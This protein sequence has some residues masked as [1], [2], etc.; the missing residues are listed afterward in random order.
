MNAPE[1]ESREDLQ[2]RS[3][4]QPAR[5]LDLQRAFYTRDPDYVPP[6][7]MA[8]SWQLDPRK[9]P[10]FR[11]ADVGLFAAF[12][13]RTCVG[14]VSTCRDRLHDEFHGDRI[15][16][17]GHFEAADANVARALVEHSGTW[18]RARGADALRGPVDLSTNNRCGLRIDD[19][20]GP[21]V[22][23]MPHN[24]PSYAG[25][26]EAAGLQKAK[27]LLAL[28][29]TSNELDH[30]RIDR[31]AA[32]LQKKAQVTL[33]N[34]DM[35]RFDAECE[36][37]WKLYERI[38]ERNWGFVPMPHDEFLAQARDLKKVAHPALL[39]IAESK[40]VPIAF[41]LALP[42]VNVGAVACGGRLFPFGWWKFLSALKK[43]KT[44]R[45]LTLG[46]TAEFRR[47]G[48]DVL[49]MHRVTT[50]GE[51]A[52]FR[53]CEASWILEDNRDM[54]GPLETM[55]FRAYRRYRIYEKSLR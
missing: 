2:I 17:F 9:N 18:C 26:L 30:E 51:A 11:H 54:L 6:V 5:F 28:W 27:D 37:L 53:A 47:A 40:G 33:R 23:M 55:G 13:G 45:V 15:G 48:I 31:I 7:T 29:V 46:V 50:Q 24:P 20:G 10:F 22:M 34:L 36:V 16:F 49:L 19:A 44:I 14:R 43:T 25:W 12:R 21:P 4:P 39:H 38:W 35:K 8:E 3:V 52:G 42:D 32:H 41:A 1:K